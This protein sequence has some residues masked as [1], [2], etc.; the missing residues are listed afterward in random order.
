MTNTHVSHLGL[1]LIRE[2]DTSI[3][4]AGTLGACKRMA[5]AHGME[6]ERYEGRTVAVNG[7]YAITTPVDTTNPNRIW[8]INGGMIQKTVGDYTLVM[9]RK[10]WNE[11]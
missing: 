9:P 7:R 4:F 6:I 3:V 11:Q 8:F 5:F 10:V 2:T 1:E